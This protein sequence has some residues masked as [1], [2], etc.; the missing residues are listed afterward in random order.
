MKKLLLV[1][2]ALFALSCTKKE[3]NEG[4]FTTVQ[5]FEHDPTT[6]VLIFEG[7]LDDFFL[8]N[9]ERGQQY[10]L[11]ITYCDRN[12]KKFTIVNK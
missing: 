10:A 7:S 3:I 1:V 12:T 2:I 9:L 5:A 6:T 8:L 4:C 11:V